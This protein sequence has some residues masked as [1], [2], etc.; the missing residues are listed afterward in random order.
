MSRQWKNTIDSLVPPDRRHDGAQMP[1]AVSINHAPERWE[2]EQL[3]THGQDYPCNNEP[4]P[5]GP[6]LVQLPIPPNAE[7]CPKHVLN[8]THHYIGSHV[9]RIVPA[10][11]RQVRHVRNIQAD[12]ERGPYPEG[13]LFSKP[14]QPK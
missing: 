9:V 8:D 14:I 2:I 12:T 11:A 3:E 1:Q 13:M 10:P 7:P 5:D 4:G 6:C